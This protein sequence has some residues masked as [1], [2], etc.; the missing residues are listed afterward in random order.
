MERETR[1]EQ[2]WLRLRIQTQSSSLRCGASLCIAICRLSCPSTS[3]LKQMNKSPSVLI[4]GRRGSNSRHPPWQGGILPLNYPRGYSII[5]HAHILM[6][7]IMIFLYK[8]L[9]FYLQL[10]RQMPAEHFPEG[11]SL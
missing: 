6:S 2:L 3:K 1:F 4:S 5:L 7:S 8:L 10:Y 11:I 9:K